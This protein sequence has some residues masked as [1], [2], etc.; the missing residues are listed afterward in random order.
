MRLRLVAPPSEPICTIPFLNAGKGSGGYTVDP[1]PIHVADVEG[2]PDDCQG[3]VATADLQGRETMPDRPARPPRLLG[4]VLPERLAAELLPELGLQASQCG[5]VLAGD[6]YTVPNLDM[7][8]GSGDVT[9][10][11]RAFGDCF[12]WVVGVAGN[13]DT[14]GDT[15]APTRVLASNVHYLDKARTTVQG[16]RVAGLGGIIGNTRKPHRRDVPDYTLAIETLLEEPTDLLVTHDG[17]DFAEWKQRGSPAVRETIERLPPVLN[18]R[19]HAHWK[20]PLAT[21][22]NGTQVLNVDCRV[23]ILKRAES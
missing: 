18:I 19:G 5:A 16:I 8:G 17:P 14:F 10:V 6:F 12:G 13:H 11:W 23:V 20:Q 1:L 21:L 15:L 7:R 22:A 4:E 9:R 2:L 3:I